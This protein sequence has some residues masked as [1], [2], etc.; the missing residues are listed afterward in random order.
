[1]ADRTGESKKGLTQSL[2]E[3]AKT[4]PINKEK[5]LAKGLASK[6]G[7]QSMNQRP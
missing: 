1:M 7:Y 2:R 4:K 5:Q 3:N 6:S